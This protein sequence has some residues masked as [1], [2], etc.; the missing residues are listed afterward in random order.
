MLEC[1]IQGLVCFCNRVLSSTLHELLHFRGRHERRTVVRNQEAVGLQGVPL[2]AHLSVTGKSSWL[3]NI[4]S[5][6]P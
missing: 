3:G 4:S 5:K 1:K 6:Q 2:E